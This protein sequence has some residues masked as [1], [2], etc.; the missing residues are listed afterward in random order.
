MYIRGRGIKLKS[1]LGFGKEFPDD[2]MEEWAAR[3]REEFGKNWAAA[4]GILRALE[5]LGI[6]MLDVHPGNIR[7]R[8]DD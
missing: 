6:Y 4:V 3:K 8:D 1:R 2:I 7:F 5:R